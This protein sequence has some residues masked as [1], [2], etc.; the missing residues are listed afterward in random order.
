MAS[1]RIA[2]RRVVLLIGLAFSAFAS[3]LVGRGCRATRQMS[4]VANAPV[5]VIDVGFVELRLHR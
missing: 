2:D 1:L 4:A 5:F 3:R